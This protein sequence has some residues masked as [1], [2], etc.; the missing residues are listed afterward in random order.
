MTPSDSLDGGGLREPT[1]FDRPTKFH[2]DLRL[3]ERHLR[4]GH[5]KV[6]KNTSVA[7]NFDIVSLL[8]P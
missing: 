4:I 6:G 1:L 8:L 7:F 5:I 2:D 3:E